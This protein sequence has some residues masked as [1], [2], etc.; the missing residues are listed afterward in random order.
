MKA[1]GHAMTAGL[2]G[3]RSDLIPAL[4]KTQAA[5]GYLSVESIREIARW[6]K[7]SDNE[8]FGV[9]TFYAQFRFQQPGRSHIKICL[10]T[11]CHVAVV[12]SWSHN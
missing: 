12:L 1:Q 8:V 2:K 10:G 6:L 9:A 3:N 11:A 4:Q 5:C 7:L